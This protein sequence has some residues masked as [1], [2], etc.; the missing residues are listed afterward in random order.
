MK[1]DK[2]A[3][4]TVLFGLLTILAIGLG[5]WVDNLGREDSLGGFFWVLL[6]GLPAAYLGWGL[7]MGGFA[8]RRLWQ[9]PL[10]T[11]LWGVAFTL[12]AVKNWIGIDIWLMLYLPAFAITAVGTVVGYGLHKLVHL[13]DEEMEKME[14]MEENKNV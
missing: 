11:G 4:S 8:V 7:L 2:R 14:K 12:A 1:L 6:M 13:K 9:W 3:V 5:F 10:L